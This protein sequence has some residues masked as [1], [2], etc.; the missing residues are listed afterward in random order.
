MGFAIERRAYLSTAFWIIGAA[1]LAGCAGDDVVSPAVTTPALPPVTAEQLVGRW[2]LGSYHRDTDRDRTVKEA[3][4]Q[5]RNPYVIKAGADG[6]VIMNLADEKEPRELL[7]KTT[8]EGR[9]F[10]GPGERPAGDLTDMEIIAVDDTSFTVQWVD[11]DVSSR[12]G[13]MVYVNCAP[14][15]A[16]TTAG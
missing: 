2:G 11:P 6:G 5:C 12:Y 14:R 15:S 13:T 16:R 4:A 8:R 3:R 9:T 7:V 1:L 10:I